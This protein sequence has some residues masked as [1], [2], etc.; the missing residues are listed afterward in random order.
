MLPHIPETRSG[1]T[2]A[3]IGRRPRRH[4]GRLVSQPP[5]P[6]GNGFEC[7]ASREAS[8]SKSPPPS[9]RRRSSAAGSAHGEEGV[10]FRCG[11]AVRAEELE[12]DFD[13][14][15][16]CTGPESKKESLV[17]LCHL[18]GQGAGRPGGQGTDGLYQ[19]RA[20]KNASETF[21]NIRRHISAGENLPGASWAAI[22]IYLHFYF[23]R[24]CV[25]MGPVRKEEAVYVK[26]L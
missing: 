13:T 3:V 25:I 24:S 12:K 19:H 15:L 7:G 20:V 11:A 26:N 23:V 1:K 22:L 21:L 16:S 4:D 6:P 8:S 10:S 18:P 17:V 9:F 14:A 5:G 2:A